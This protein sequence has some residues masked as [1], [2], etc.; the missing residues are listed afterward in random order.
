M[1]S[2][3]KQI[4]QFIREL[5][6]EPSAVIPLHSPVFSGNEKAY[7]DEC[8]DSTF[9]SSVG[10]YVDR[11]EEMASEYTGA[12]KA[13][14]SVNGT[15]ALYISL[16][17]AGVKPGNEV[18]T[19]AVTFVATANAISYTG[20]KPVFIDVDRDTLG[21]SPQKLN[22]WLKKNVKIDPKTSQ[23]IN[24]LSLCPVTACVPMH[25]FGHSC[26][27]D[28]IVDI[29]D[30]YNIPVIE[31]AAESLGS[32]YK[33]KH[34]GTFGKIGVL[35]F[36]GNKIIT[37]GGGGM[38][39]TNDVELGNHIKHLTTQAKVAH[40]WEYA[41]DFIGFNNRMPNLNA[42]LGVA[43][44]ENLES[45][46]ENKRQTAL[47]YQNFFKDSDIDFFTEPVNSQSNYWLNSILLKSREERDEFLKYTNESGI[48][49]RPI[50]KLMSKLD[51]YKNC[52]CGDLDVS[53]EIESRL[54]NLPSSV[55]L[56]S[57]TI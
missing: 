18:L 54:V 37:T 55:K 41:H 11:F 9:V 7:L 53:E 50:W 22:D 3:F 36:N 5:Y 21:L 47:S 39:L 1:Q 27:I 33:G 16:L 12:Q 4:V 2:S 56:T 17:A 57:K 35:S 20:A 45:Y 10:K 51:M 46:L 31:D 34:T 40:P 13:I 8:I 44:I 28:E 6:E 48:Q 30:Q 23:A 25:T 19:Q 38:I 24:R 15:N 32:F 43:Q 14:A 52:V 49:T 42:A 29:C 26:R